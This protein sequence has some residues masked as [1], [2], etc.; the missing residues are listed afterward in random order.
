MGTNPAAEAAFASQGGVGTDDDAAIDHVQIGSLPGTA[1][2]LPT[3]LLRSRIRLTGSGA[4]SVSKV[5]TI[6]E[7]PEII[8]RFG[9]G[10]FDAPY[11]VIRS[12]AP[13]RHGCTRGG[14]APSS[15]R[16][17]RDR[18]EE[19]GGRHRARRAPVDG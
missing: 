4:G 5:R 16:T 8:A 6:A 2:P 3:A 9:D 1:A 11:A 15:S 10:T 19:C 12:V 18:F 14:P 7:V 17:D 13:A